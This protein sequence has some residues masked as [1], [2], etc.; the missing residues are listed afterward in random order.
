MKETLEDLRDAI[1]FKKTEV[2]N[3]YDRAEGIS[4]K[5]KLFISLHKRTMEIGRAH[6]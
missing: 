2:K 5:V 4:A 3:M 6:V 1:N